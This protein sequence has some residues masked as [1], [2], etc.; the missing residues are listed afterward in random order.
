MDRAH[1][2]EDVDGAVDV[3]GVEGAEEDDA[4]FFG[5]DAVEC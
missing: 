4:V 1:E 3:D 2:L 5:D